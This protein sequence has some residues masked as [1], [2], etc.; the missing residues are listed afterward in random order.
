MNLFLASLLFLPQAAA[1]QEPAHRLSPHP[2]ASDRFES[3]HAESRSE[4]LYGL[5]GVDLLGFPPRSSGRVQALT[6]S[7]DS[8]KSTGIQA[9]WPNGVVPYRFDGNV[10]SSQRT[11][12]LAAMSVLEGIADVVFVPRNGEPAFLH[13]QDDN[14]NFSTSVGFNGGQVTIGLFN[15][16][17]QGIIIHELYHALGFWHEHQRFDRGDFVQVVPG[18][19]QG[20]W[21][22]QFQV[23]NSLLLG[24]YDHGS[25][26][27][28]GE[29]AASICCPFDSDCNCAPN[30]QTI[31]APGFESLMGQRDELSALDAHGLRSLYP[32]PG[33][34]FV[35][36]DAGPG[37]GSGTG[38]SPWTQ[39]QSAINLAPSGS[40]VF[41][42]PGDYDLGS[43]WSKPL[44]VAG[45]V[46]GI[47]VH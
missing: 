26:M 10:S 5:Y 13:I 36:A 22:Q 21:Q 33:W 45:P 2:F 23:V 1:I 18:N 17:F 15:W 9:T 46:G 39:L 28:Y 35:D 44:I 41:A 40:T 43:T 16:G 7:T 38:T 29:C 3:E 20:G 8:S 32:E 14:G 34:R 31:V 11:D 30:C 27:H 6:C 24:P 37:A 12:A 47:R 25:L 19:I 4:G 42:T